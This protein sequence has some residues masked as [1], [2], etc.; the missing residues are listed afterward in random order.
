MDTISQSPDRPEIPD[1]P[2]AAKISAGANLHT[3]VR[4]LN[5]ILMVRPRHTFFFAAVIMTVLAA[6]YCQFVPGPVSD[7][8]KTII[9]VCIGLP[10]AMWFVQ[11]FCGTRVRFDCSNGEF[12]IWGI[13]HTE[14]KGASTRLRGVQFC[15]GKEPGGKPNAPDPSFQVNLVLEKDGK[16]IRYNVLDCANEDAMRGIAGEIAAFMNVEFYCAKIA[17]KAKN[18]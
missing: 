6:L 13:S 7:T 18:K 1:G 9:G 8:A 11:Q 12:Q 5:H 14:F 17:F 15:R 2:A 16:I 10:S 4:P 3:L